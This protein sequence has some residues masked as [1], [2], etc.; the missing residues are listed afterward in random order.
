MYGALRA[1]VLMVD[2]RGYGDSEGHP[3]EAGLMLDADAVLDYVLSGA[4][5]DIAP[6]KVVLFG[7]SLGGAVAVYAAHKHGA[8]VAAVVLENTFLSI[9][10]MVDA[11]FPVLG[12]IKGLLLRCVGM[13]GGG[14]G[15]P[16]CCLWA[17][18]VCF[19]EPARMLARLLARLLACVRV[20]LSLPLTEAVVDGLRTWGVLLVWV[21][22]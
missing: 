20:C 4:N 17:M 21:G 8:R 12:P 5:P 2:Y 6:G 19:V 1:N 10:A 15:G 9:A 13:R 7:S 11:V 14:E 3:T 22:C 16:F 18:W